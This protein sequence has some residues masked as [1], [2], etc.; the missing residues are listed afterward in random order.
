MILSISNFG[1]LVETIQKTHNALQNQSAKAVNMGLTIRNWLIGYY[2]VE[3]EQNG[4]DRANYGD[5]LLYK[6]SKK[7]GIR[8][9]SETNLKNTRLF[10]FAYPEISQLMTDEFITNGIIT[11][12]S[13]PIT[14][15]FKLNAKDLNHFKS[16][17]SNVSF[18]HFVE[19][20]KIDNPVKR[21]YYELL[22]LKT[23]PSVHNLKEK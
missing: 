2:I 10:Y 18:T 3:F 19:L 15:E 16:M 1:E 14:D 7:I 23:Q 11:K 21:K 9:L 13:Q 5:E 6:L 12:K 20:I 4:E 17:V 8:G 22:I